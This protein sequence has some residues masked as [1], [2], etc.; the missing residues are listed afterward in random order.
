MTARPLPLLLSLLLLAAGSL[1]FSLA[2][3][4]VETDFIEISR[5]NRL[6]ATAGSNRTVRHSCIADLLFFCAKSSH[7][8]ERFC[9]ILR[10][11]G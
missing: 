7:K 4:S 6:S 2:T 11:E 3:G 10:L 5:P 9:A 1:L 8:F